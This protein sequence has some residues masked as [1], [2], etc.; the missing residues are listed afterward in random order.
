MKQER[1]LPIPMI[2]SFIQ[3]FRGQRVI[4]DQDLAEI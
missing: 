3:T 1:Y 4:I 2:E